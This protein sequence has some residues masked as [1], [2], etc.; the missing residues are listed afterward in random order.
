MAIALSTAGILVKW[1]CET[2]AGTRPTSGFTALPDVKSIP[3]FG[4]DVNALQSTPLSATSNHTYI[5]GLKDSGGS[6]GL[7]VNL[8]DDFMTAWNNLISA[9]TTANSSSKATWFEYAIPGMAKS[10]FFPGK[11]IDLGFGGADVDEVLED[12]ANILPVGDFT[13]ATAS[14]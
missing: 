6:I 4:S 1:C 8:S 9:Y 10:F 13:W 5:E 7:T 14:T 3:E 2:T 12:T 11:P